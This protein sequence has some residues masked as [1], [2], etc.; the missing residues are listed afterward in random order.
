MKR[1]LGNVGVICEQVIELSAVNG[2]ACVLDADAVLFQRSDGFVDDLPVTGE[3]FRRREI[4]FDKLDIEGQGHKT[5]QNL[6]KGDLRHFI[7][8]KYD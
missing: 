1:A 3:A 5:R 2:H 8:V 4:N 6:G 7:T